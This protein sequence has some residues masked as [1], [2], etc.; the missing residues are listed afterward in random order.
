MKADEAVK[1]L[2]VGP[3]SLLVGVTVESIWAGE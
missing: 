3:T 1:E 2:N